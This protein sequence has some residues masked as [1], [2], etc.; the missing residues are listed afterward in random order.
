[1]KIRNSFVSNS[2]SSSFVVVGARLSNKELEKLGWVTYDKDNDF[3]DE[4]PPGDIDVIYDDGGNTY[5]VGKA[6]AEGDEYLSN[7]DYSSDE[8]KDLFVEMK[9]RLKR[10][11]KLLIGTMQ[12]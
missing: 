6:L 9:K 8:I 10:D 3:Y 7:V 2:S 5:I 1:M 11:V 12:C 4:T